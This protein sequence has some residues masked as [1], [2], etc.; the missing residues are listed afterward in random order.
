MQREKADR[1]FGRK[2]RCAAH[3]G[4]C[5]I[6]AR[7]ICWSSPASRLNQRSAV[8]RICSN[9]SLRS[10]RPNQIRGVRT[11]GPRNQQKPHDRGR[12]LDLNRATYFRYSPDGAT[13][14]SKGV[15]AVRF[16][17]MLPVLIPSDSP[18]TGIGMLTAYFDDSGTHDQ[19]DV[20]IWAGL[21]GNQYQWKLFDELWVAKLRDPAPGKVPISHF[22]MVDCEHGDN[23]FLYWKR[24]EREY[25]ARE[26][27][28]IINKCM[29]SGFAHAV[30]RKDWDELI[31]GSKR[32]VHGD[33]E[34]FSMRTC[35]AGAMH[36]AINEA[37]Y[38]KELALVFDSRP[39]RNKQNQAV[40]DLLERDRELQKLN[41][42]NQ[43]F[44]K[45]SV[46]VVSLTFSSAAKFRPLQ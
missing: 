14:S 25:L 28:E 8:R 46:D 15:N 29:L 6:L 3:T 19:S 45:P 18:D 4:Q 21:F 11:N 16:R 38:D 20:V 34:A 9:C 40:F 33:A 30:S 26:L 35:Y 24:H 36:W 2:P 17:D 13:M 23:E 10:R 31:V 39:H 22:H 44:P 32:D 1:F 7:T 41:L 43:F 12:L 42:A 5:W 37:G 27:V